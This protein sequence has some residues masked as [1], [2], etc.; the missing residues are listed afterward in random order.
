MKQQ[1]KI[2]LVVGVVIAV[3]I[4]YLIVSKRTTDAPIPATALSVQAPTTFHGFGPEGTGGDPLLNKQKNR[5]SAPQSFR[6]VSVD[7]ILS[8]PH[9]ELDMVGKKYRSKWGSSANNQ[10]EQYESQGVR[11]TGYL[12]AAKESGPESCNGHS[13]SLRDY[14]LWITSSPDVNK[15]TG[16]I[17]EMTP[18]WKEQF[19]EWRLRYIQA[20][21]RNNA[22]V[23][24]SG[25]VMWDQ[26]HPDEVGKSRGSQ[27]EVHPVT[28]FEVQS[29]GSWRQLN[30]DLAEVR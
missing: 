16:V 13:D 2:L 5:W 25:W 8:F 14:H 29:G 18:Y 11:V 9:T 10:L 27:W 1:Q 22:K 28:L 6:D 30:G 21:V 15:N 19:P 24:I 17:V 23:R 12:V 26:E 4:V 20:L 3:V 7:D